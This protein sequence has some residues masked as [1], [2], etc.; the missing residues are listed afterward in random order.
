[1]RIHFP[2]LAMKKPYV[3]RFV[4]IKQVICNQAVS[5]VSAES[6]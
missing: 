4:L 1:M 6:D 2:N 3:L 5:S